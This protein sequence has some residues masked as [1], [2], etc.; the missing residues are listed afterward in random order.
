MARNDMV[1]KH[2]KGFI[3]S[4]L[5]NTFRG[6]LFGGLLFGGIAALVTVATG[7]LALPLVAA[8]AVGGGL[9][10]GAVNGAAGTAR[11]GLETIGGIVGLNRP[12]RG[13][14]GG[15]DEPGQERQP[16]MGLAEGLVTLIGAAMGLQSMKNKLSNWAGNGQE[17]SSQDYAAPQQQQYAPR[18]Q[19]APSAFM[20]PQMPDILADRMQDGRLHLTK[21]ELANPVIRDAVQN[22]GQQQVAYRDALIASGRRD[23]MEQARDLNAKALEFPGYKQESETFV[24]NPEHM[25]D[26]KIV[27]HM[28]KDGERREKQ[29]VKELNSELKELRREAQDIS[30]G[31]FEQNFVEDLP[32]R[33]AK[34]EVDTVAPKPQEQAPAQA[35]APSAP[36]VEQPSVKVTQVPGSSVGQ[37]ESGLIVPKA[38]ANLQ[39]ALQDSAKIGQNLSSQNV[40]LVGE[41]GAARAGSATSQAR[42][43][44][45]ALGGG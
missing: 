11:W 9:L 2:K 20:P 29:N 17:Q 15:Y 30:R 43:Q 14:R 25:M 23:M 8:A 34:P 18:G 5:G 44:G 3:N 16:R 41:A 13:G 37:T 24:I 42:P 10:C 12:D 35:A 1:A 36:Q 7:G 4:T 21:D 45:Q 32:Q 39:Q 33:D 6:G 26:N 28:S 38:G 22:F 19:Q 27:K 40:K 31:R